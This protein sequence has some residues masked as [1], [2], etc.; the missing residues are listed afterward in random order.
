MLSE[1][2]LVYLTWPAPLM[3]GLHIGAVIEPGAVLR[4]C[5]ESISRIYFTL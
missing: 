3:E 2:V 5:E 1:K 4:V